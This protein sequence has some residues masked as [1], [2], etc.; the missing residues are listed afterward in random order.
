MIMLIKDQD[1]GSKIAIKQYVPIGHH[2]HCSW[3]WK[4]NITKMCGGGK[5]VNSGW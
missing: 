3:H 5:K 4:G 1:K 2:F